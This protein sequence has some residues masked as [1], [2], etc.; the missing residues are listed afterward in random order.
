MSSEENH[1]FNFFSVIMFFLE[2]FLSS[3]LLAFQEII[4]VPRFVTHAAQL[5]QLRK[6][7]PMLSV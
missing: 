4:E 5:H 6:T 7:Q 3:N 1:T 2:D